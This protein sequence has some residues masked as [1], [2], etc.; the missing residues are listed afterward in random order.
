MTDERSPCFIGIDLG[1]TNIHAGIV[2]INN[3]VLYRRFVPTSVREGRNSVIERIINVIQELKGQCPGSIKGI[4]VGAAGII[5]M[6]RGN[7][8][9][10]PNFPG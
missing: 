4:G 8:I 6:K 10:S 9:T 1:G 5:D 7:I 3:E 2:N